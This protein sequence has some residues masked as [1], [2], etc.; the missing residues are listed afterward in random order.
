MSTNAEIVR[1]VTD[2]MGRGDPL[3]VLA[4]VSNEVR[5]AVS[6]HD[7][8]SAPW[9]KEF[10][11]KPGVAAFFEELS[12]MVFSEFTVKAIISEGDLVMS[13]LHVV[14]AGPNGHSVDMDEVQ[15]WRFLDG[16]IISFDAV[17][18]T[19]SVVAAFT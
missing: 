10:R 4:Y 9:F 1:R 15:I 8:D 5:W 11:G 13:W 2:A 3:G 14:F 18:D 19:A 16:K 12:K 7:R 17:L 6:T